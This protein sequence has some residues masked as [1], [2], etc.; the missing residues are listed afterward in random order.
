MSR[1]L[2]LILLLLLPQTSLAKP[3][4]YWTHATTRENG[5]PLLKEDIAGMRLYWER[6]N[7]KGKKASGVS[8]LKTKSS[9]CYSFTVKGN[10]IFWGETVLKD[11]LVSNPSIKLPYVLE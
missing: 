5:T 2:L 7:L 6:V 8:S 10:Y 4:L 1:K 9:Y 11:G 3:C